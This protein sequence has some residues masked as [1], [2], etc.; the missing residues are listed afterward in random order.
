[1]PILTTLD[2]IPV[3]S[4]IKETLKYAEERGLGR[5]YHFHRFSTGINT[6]RTGYMAGL[7]HKDA[8]NLK[9]TPGTSYSV[10]S[11]IRGSGGSGRSRGGY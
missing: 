4:S 1:M 5:T 2:G 7:S 8:L 6:Y 10:S 3:F 9:L 11:S